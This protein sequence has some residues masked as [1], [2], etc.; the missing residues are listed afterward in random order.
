M[1]NMNAEAV[2]FEIKRLQDCCKEYRAELKQ[3][4][5]A[6]REISKGEGRYAMTPL[7]HAE[8][9]IEDM[10][11]IALAALEG[12]VVRDASCLDSGCDIDGK[13][14][15]KPWCDNALAVL[16]TEQVER[17]GLG[18]YDD[19]MVKLGYRSGQATDENEKLRTPLGRD[20]E[21]LEDNARLEAELKQANAR[22]RKAFIAGWNG[23]LCAGN[24]DEEQAW[25]Q[26]RCQNN[27]DW[28]AL[29]TDDLQDKDEMTD[30]IER[31]REMRP[32]F[33]QESHAIMHEAA[34][35]IERLQ[36]DVHNAI[37]MRDE[38]ATKL[39]NK[40]ISRDAEIERLTNFNSALLT[41]LDRIEI[42]DD[43]SLASQR[44]DI[45]EE[46]GLTVEFGEKVSSYDN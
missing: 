40:N 31:L 39:L 29:K 19:G 6:L 42:K 33:I 5:A 3:A 13:E 1:T 24:T 14:P 16:E 12:R 8:N 43:A 46:N 38:F 20:I 4:N 11:A 32:D 27:S 25:Q 9:T 26:Y 35:E 30:L 45:A 21:L 18:T 36:R 7:E 2:E 23:G 10:I 41:L 15:H 17:P 37:E 22:E 34:D 28:A 44:F